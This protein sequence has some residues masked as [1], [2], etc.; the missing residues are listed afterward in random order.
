MHTHHLARILIVSLTLVGAGALAIGA[1]AASIESGQPA[2]KRITRSG[3]DG[4]KLGMTHAQLRQRGLVGRIRRGCELGGPNTRSARLL[5][6]LR[7][8]VNYTLRSP[9]RV[10]DITIRGGARARGVGIGS[11]IRAIRRAFPRARVDHSTEDV[12]RLTLVKTPRRNGRRITF[13]VSTTTKRTTVI[14]VPFI[15][16][17]E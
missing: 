9:R 12:F 11:T 3:V 6:P 13:G 1:V 2:P 16:F 15:A 7:G 8:Q 17:C 4:V 14:G 10:R 5:P